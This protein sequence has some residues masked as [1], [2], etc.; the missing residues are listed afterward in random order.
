MS[1][2]IADLRGFYDSPLGAMTCRLVARTLA[3]S[4]GD[5]RGLSLLGLGYAT[6]YL[7]ELGSG[8]ERV[9]AF[10]PAEQGAVRWPGGARSACAL[11]DPLAMPL[12][13]NAIDRVLAIHALET[14]ES[15]VDLLHEIA[16]VLS[17]TGRALLVCPNRRGLWARMDST[18]FGH[19]Q[20]YSRKQLRRLL[21]ETMLE[22]EAW[23]ETL[24]M[25]PLTRGIVLRGAPVWERVGRAL[26]L[27]FAGL[28]VVEVAKR[29][30]RPV[31]VRERRRAMRLR[32][33]FA[34][35]PASRSSA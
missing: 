31:P 19:G 34:P 1:V 16:R 30:H 29:W 9:S 15:P 22:P 13:D 24:Y 28:H 7:P 4:W 35:A 12:A 3:R 33:V 14:V 26:S 2:D 23:A 25:P 11:A 21:R 10:M 5:L 8:C 18:P 27:P 6:P 17:P 32:P 20:P